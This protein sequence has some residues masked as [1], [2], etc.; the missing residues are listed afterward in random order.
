MF[1]VVDGARFAWLA[2]DKYP[3]DTDSFGMDESEA[4]YFERFAS[5]LADILLQIYSNVA[6]APIA[7]SM[8]FG[9][10]Y[11]TGQ[12][13]A[14]EAWRGQPRWERTLYSSLIGF[15]ITIIVGIPV[16]LVSFYFEVLSGKELTCTIV[17]V[18]L[19]GFVETIYITRMWAKRKEKEKS[20]L[21]LLKRSRKR[22]LQSLSPERTLTSRFMSSSRLG[23]HSIYLVPDIKLQGEVWLRMN[24]VDIGARGRAH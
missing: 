4:G 2:S 13:L 5:H 17:I 7:L 21:G 12:I 20:G 1:Q 6:L 23:I 3:C 22:M 11:A 18:G 8:P 24:C 9:T 16:A 14:G 15:G 19:V 10:G